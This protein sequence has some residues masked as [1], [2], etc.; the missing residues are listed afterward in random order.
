M[1]KHK[2]VKDYKL[3]HSV[4]DRGRMH[5][6]AEYAGELF[7]FRAPLEQVR[8]QGIRAAVACAVGW[9]CWLGSLFLNTGAMRC[10]Y[11]SL[12][13]AFTALPLW[14]L[15]SSIVTAL[16]VKPPMYRR[17]S[18]QVSMFYP[19]AALWCAALPAVSLVGLAVTAAL[20]KGNLVMQDGI[21]ALCGAILVACACFCFSL[22]KSFVTEP[23][24]KRGD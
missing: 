5:T 11:I 16:T 7:T 15:S 22:R 13:Y 4:D 2:Y 21:F 20:G 6:S 8:Q 17:Q 14:K 3:V 1:A 18:H 23:Q 10:F 19:P 9:A 24:E 12:P